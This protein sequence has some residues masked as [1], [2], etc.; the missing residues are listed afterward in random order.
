MRV[1]VIG[2]SGFVGSAFCRLLA[3]RPGVELVAIQRSNYVQHRGQSSDLVIEA[4]G[5]SKKFLADQDPV[6]EFD[7][8][9][10]HRL[11]TL[12]DFPAA[13]HLHLSSVDVYSDLTSPDTTREDSPIDLST[14]SRYGL[15][16]LL[17][18]QL[19]RGYAQRWL[20]LRLAGMVGPNLRKNP[21]YDLLKGQPLRIHPDSQY[22]FLHTDDVATAAWQLIERGCSGQILNL[23]GDGLISPREIAALA[24]R[25]MNLSLLPPDARPRI[26]NASVEKVRQLIPLPTTRASV[27][28]FLRESGAIAP[29]S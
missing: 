1:V 22:Q 7:A 8:S 29:R 28:R 27:E 3:T 11:R 15:H 2:S 17:A 12:R 4:A 9:V 20:I 19:V 26:V 10:T 5:N 18:E 13:M 21:V 6:A 24:N 16:K 14:T 25:E 23:A